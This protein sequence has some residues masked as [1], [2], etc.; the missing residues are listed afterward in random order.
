MR[1]VPKS[2]DVGQTAISGEAPV[3]LVF[4]EPMPCSE[5]PAKSK[6]MPNNT[7]V[8]MRLEAVEYGV[9]VGECIDRQ[10]ILHVQV[11]YMD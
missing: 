6:E 7:L 5:Q 9:F 1:W 3:L 8:Y 10:P 2:N 4:K 11:V